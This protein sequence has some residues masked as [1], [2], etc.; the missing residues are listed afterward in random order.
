MSYNVDNFDIKEMVGFTLPL[1]F[2]FELTDGYVRIK[3]GVYEFSEFDVEGMEIIGNP[4]HD[5]EKLVVTELSYYGTYS[6]TFWDSFIDLL[7]RSH[8]RL[9]ARVTWEGGDSV[10]I[11]TVQSGKI[12]REEV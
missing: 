1:P 8:G 3:D 7:K 12:A 9:R 6:G 10:E 11:L 2:L 4:I 5:E